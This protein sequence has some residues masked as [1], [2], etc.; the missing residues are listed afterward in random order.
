MSSDPESQSGKQ[1]FADLLNGFSFSSSRSPKPEREATPDRAAR[2][3][4][5]AERAPEAEQPDGRQDDRP[6]YGDYPYSEVGYNDAPAYERG[7]GEPEAGHADGGYPD[8]GYP[9]RDYSDRDYSDRDY[10]D[11]DYSDRDYSDRGYPDSGYADGGHADAG[12]PA[13]PEDAPSIVRAYSW[14]GGRTTSTY[15]LE[16]E[17]LVSAAEWDHPAALGMKAEHQEVIALCGR[18]RSVAEIAALLKVP[19]GVAKVLLGD[20]A[21]RGLIDVHQTISS[22]D[23]DQPNMGLMER[24][25]AGLRRL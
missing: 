9:D 3:A 24:V 8:G 22:E 13:E 20:M 6:E 5:R 23:G 25:L 15:Q 4:R 14:T 7:Y 12:H 1:S 19:L 10:S 11:R 2:R 16:L 18:P 21:E 17:T